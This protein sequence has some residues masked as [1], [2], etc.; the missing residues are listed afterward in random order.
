MHSQEPFRLYIHTHFCTIAPLL[1]K[2]PSRVVIFLQPSGPSLSYILSPDSLLRKLPNIL[3]ISQTLLDN[4]SL[5]PRTPLPGSV[6][7]DHD[8]LYTY[9]VYCAL[10]Q[11]TKARSIHQTEESRIASTLYYTYDGGGWDTPLQHHASHLGRGSHWAFLTDCLVAFSLGW[12]VIL[13]GL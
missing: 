2:P 1:T 3:Y 6:R 13:C 8:S 5:V 10:V 4:Q 7:N 9:T 11:Y 12:Q